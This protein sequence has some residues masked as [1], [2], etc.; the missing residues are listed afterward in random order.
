LPAAAADAG[1]TVRVESHSGQFLAWAAFSPAS[2]IRARVWS[3]DENSASTQLFPRP[4]R[5]RHAVRGSVSTSAATDA[6]GPWRIRRPAGPDRGPLWR[7]AGGAV[8]LSAGA[9]RWKAALAD[10]CWRRP[11]QPA[12]RALRRQRRASGGLPEATGWLRGDGPTE[13][14]IREHDWRLGLDI[15]RATRP[16]STWTSATAGKRFADYARRLGF[17]R[18]LNCYCYT[19]GFTVAAW[20]RRG[21]CHLDRLVRKAGA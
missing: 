1:E 18:V 17:Q 10:A 14:S 13:L 8:H 3:F 21:P 4:V 5:R 2:R 19:G 16:A 9:E 15:A 20:R 12:V 11:A 7:H 6:P